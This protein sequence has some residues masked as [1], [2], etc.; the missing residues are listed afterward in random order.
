[1][2]RTATN[3]PR[4]RKCGSTTLTAT[5]S[6]QMRTIKGRRRHVSDV[7]CDHCGHS[8]WSVHP[9]IR[10]LARKADRARTA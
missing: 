4:C 9:A 6:Q 7:T 5:S 2:P 1:M 3:A 10:A 8:W